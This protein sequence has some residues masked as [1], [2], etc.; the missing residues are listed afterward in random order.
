MFRHFPRLPHLTHIPSANSWGLTLS[1]VLLVTL[2]PSVSVGQAPAAKSKPSNATDWPQFLGPQRNGI[3]NETGLIDDWPKGGLK[4]TWRVGGGVGM[5]GLVV[6]RGTAVTMLQDQAGQHVVALDALTG[7]TKW[8]TRVGKPYKNSMGDGPRA[9][10]AIHADAVY[11][12]SGDGILSAHRFADGKPIWQHDT[13]AELGGKVADYGMACSPLIVGDLVIVTVG[14]PNAAVVAYHCKTGKLAWKAGSDSAGYSSPA[15]L[16]V[17]DQQQLV[18]FTGASA[19]G[20]S[21]D[22][23]TQLWRYPYKTNFDCNIAT[24]LAHKGNVFISSGENHG[25]SLLSIAKGSDGFSVKEIWKSHGPASVMRNGWQTSIAHNGHLFG[26]DNVGAA[27][28]LT[29]LNCVNIET[30]KRIW[31]QKRF[32]NGNLIAADGKLILTTMKGDLVFARLSTEG[33]HEIGRQKVIGKTRQS[34]VLANG[35]LYLRDDR[36][37]VC[38]DVRKAH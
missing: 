16:R 25:C 20:I 8:K 7:K 27:T 34:A 10:P 32:G 31:Q 9:T 2:V 35:R 33:Y 13:I 26:L 12:F 6:S 18:V 11:S 4:E 36:E 30:G 21:P 29:H 17:G 37:I 28:A 1:L 5:S 15:L 23:G 14:A 3:S 19:I 24:P 22:K 38:I